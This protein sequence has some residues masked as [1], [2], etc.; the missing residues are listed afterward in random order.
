MLQRRMRQNRIRLGT[1]FY[2][3]FY[4]FLSSMLHATRMNMF[5]IVACSMLQIFNVVF[6][7]P[8]HASKSQE[9]SLMTQ[10]NVRIKAR[11][12]R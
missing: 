9:N 3:T 11:I 6:V 4:K 10:E 7:W 1:A 12:F 8:H 2:A 5:I